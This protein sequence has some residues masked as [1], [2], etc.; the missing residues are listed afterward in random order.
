M[1][2]VLLDDSSV[3]RAVARLDSDAGLNSALVEDILL[4]YS[5]NT[6]LLRSVSSYWYCALALE[7]PL[8][9]HGTESTLD[10]K[11]VGLSLNLLGLDGISRDLL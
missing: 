7:N 5:S 1:K 11:A 8:G 10:R 3:L 4:D 2:N 9:L 6:S